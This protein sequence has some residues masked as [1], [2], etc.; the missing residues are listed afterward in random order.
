[1]LRLRER[2]GAFLRIGRR[3]KEIMYRR[4]GEE[5]S[6]EILLCGP[7]LIAPRAHAHTVERAASTKGPKMFM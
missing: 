5:N 1:M 4:E 6:G 3:W 7:R 2:R